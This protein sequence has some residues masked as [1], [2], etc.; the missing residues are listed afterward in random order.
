MLKFKKGKIKVYRGHYAMHI[1][2]VLVDIEED[3]EERVL[4][5]D[6]R[7]FLCSSTPYMEYLNNVM[8][9]YLDG[10]GTIW[11]SEVEPNFYA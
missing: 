1:L 10:S 6:C 3:R 5:V 8:D 9:C 7:K 11:L 2:R 4:F